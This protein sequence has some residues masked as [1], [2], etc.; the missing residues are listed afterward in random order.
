MDL[1]W[2]LR[3]TTGPYGRPELEAAYGETAISLHRGCL[4]DVSSGRVVGVSIWCITHGRHTR[5][6]TSVGTVYVFLFFNTKPICIMF[7]NIYIYIMKGH[8]WFLTLS[9]LDD[10]QWTFLTAH[11]VFIKEMRKIHRFIAYCFFWIE[12]DLHTCL[13]H[14]TCITTCYYMLSLSICFLC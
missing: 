14:T 4:G 11:D 3:S 9:W 1:W 6:N 8:W 7:S 2:W 5:V 12:I 10:D 13:I